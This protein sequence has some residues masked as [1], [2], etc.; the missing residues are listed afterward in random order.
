MRVRLSD[1]AAARDLC[2]FLREQAGAV[3]EQ[4]GGRGSRTVEVSLL[5]SYGEEAL[6]REVEAAVRR[7]AF[8]R[9]PHDRFEIG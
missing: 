4:T 1:P 9:S 6:R 2:E 5:G 3:V 8:A 7:W